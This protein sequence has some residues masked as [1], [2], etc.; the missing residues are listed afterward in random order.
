M[1]HFKIKLFGALAFLLTAVGCF[2]DL[3]TIPIDPD[4]VTGESVYRDPTAYE[5]VLAKLYA[6]YAVSG[7]EGPAGKADISGIDEGFGQYLRGYWYHQELTT[8]E[9]VIGWNDQTIKDFHAQTWTP[10]DG[11]IYAFYSRI[12]YQIAS[13]NEFVRETTEDRLNERGVDN[14]LRTQIKAYRAEA[15]FLRALSYWHALDLFRNPPFPTEQDVIGAFVPRQTNPQELFSYIESELKAIEG[16]L[17]DPQAVPF[18]RAS[19]AAAWTLL[20]K[21]YLNAEVY[22]NQRKYD[23]CLANCQKVI[24]AGFTLEPEYQ[25]LF[26]ADNDKSK[27]I[28]FPVRFDGVRTRTWGGMTF[29]IRAGIGGTM[30]PKTSGVASGWGGTRTTP[31][32]IDKFPADLTGVLIEYNPG[33]TATYPKL[34][35]P[36]SHQGFD[37]TQTENSLAA[38]STI[39]PNNRIYEGYKYFPDNNTQIEFTTIPANSGPPRWGDNG[40]DG[41]LE[42]GGAKIVVPQAGF[43]YIRVNL[44]DRKYVIEK[45]DFSIL[46]SATG[47]ADLAMQWD[48]AAKA[49]VVSA[50]LSAGSFR[51]RANRSDAV[52]YGD[53]GADALLELGGTEI[54]VAAGS[55]RLLLDLDKPD[56]TFR[57]LNTSFDRR[58][59]FYTSGQNKEINDLTIFN[60]GYAVNKFKNVTSDGR[61]GSNNDFPDTDFP[62]F[63]L[64]DVYLMAAEAIL[65]NNGNKQQA[66]DFVNI[67]RQRAYKGSGGNFT[68]NNLTLEAL[69]DERARELYWE[70]HRRTDLIRFGQFT[71]GSYL[72]AWKGGVKGGAATAVTRNVFP[73]PANDRN[74]NPQLKQNDG[75]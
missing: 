58:G 23:E 64:A 13:V 26:L 3:D 33:K 27:E 19:K 72:W 52:A 62:M 53:N 30:D 66:L 10:A 7:Q 63:R 47:N 31:Q 39:A 24:N 29:V 67:V 28:I 38:T 14:S 68:A 4:V 5:K 2:K 32:F 74:A 50:N 49:L 37:A 35:V 43:Y 59:K 46:G 71:N 34:Y 36:G 8:D 6:G 18:G 44:N 17:L 45:R 21:L 25:D 9:A 51:F 54:N 73:I 55:Y 15:R 57:L 48:T 16:D 65:R 41:T 11:F 69:L 70:C 22:V 20:A 40:G 56:Y 60:D 42:T 61:Q 12:F 75:Y 1:T